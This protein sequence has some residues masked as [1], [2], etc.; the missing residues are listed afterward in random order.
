MGESITRDQFEAL[1]VGS[2]EAFEAFFTARP[3]LIDKEFSDSNKR[4]LYVAAMLTATDLGDKSRM[5]LSKLKYLLSTKKVNVNGVKISED[6]SDYNPLCV[7]LFCF[8]FESNSEANMMSAK[9]RTV[10]AIK[11]LLEAGADVND[12]RISERGQTPLMLASYSFF[13]EAV[14]VLLQFKA[15]VNEVTETGKTS[16]IYASIVGYDQDDAFNQPY[17]TRERKTELLK[18]LLDAGAFIDAQDQ[19]GNSALMHTVISKDIEAFEFLMQRGANIS[20]KN[21]AGQSAFDLATPAFRIKL[22][23]FFKDLVASKTL[24]QVQ[25]KK[26]LA[27]QSSIPPNTTSLVASFLGAPSK[28]ARQPPNTAQQKQTVLGEL[29]ATPSVGTFPGGTDYQQALARNPQG[30]RRTKKA[31]KH[32]KKRK[33]TRKYK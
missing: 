16:L 10:E 17:F 19:D 1:I 5:A 32:K 4:P 22:R 14:K 21:R 28:P 12:L 13:V 11:A 31:R 6:A 9:D 2:D 8:V 24:E 29:K 27:G 7:A 33:Y 18:V 30:G 3:H 26:E 15:R 20:L 23:P 25:N